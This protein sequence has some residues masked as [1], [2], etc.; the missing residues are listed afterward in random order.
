MD[1]RTIISN[2]IKQF[3]R[4]KSVCNMGKPTRQRWCQDFANVNDACGSV[5]T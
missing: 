4:T 5:S 2:I 3:Y 1:G